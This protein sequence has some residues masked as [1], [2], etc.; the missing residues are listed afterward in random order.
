MNFDHLYW[1]EKVG[2]SKGKNEIKE[3]IEK[4]K[5][6]I[7]EWNIHFQKWEVSGSSPPT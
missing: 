6:E 7:K 2:T 4:V 5:N 1:G 3:W